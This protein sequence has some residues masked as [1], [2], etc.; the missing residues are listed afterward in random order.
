MS[1]GTTG[2]AVPGAIE[3]PTGPRLPNPAPR[4]LAPGT[5]PGAG[6]GVGWVTT[7]QAVPE[8]IE[9]PTAPRLLE[10]AT[11]GLAPGIGSGTRTHSTAA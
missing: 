3:G 11:R 7:G 9:A 10:L 4:G 2:Q 1:W 8:D 6:I 5:A